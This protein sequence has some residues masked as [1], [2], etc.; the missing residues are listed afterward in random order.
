M[1]DPASLPRQLSLKSETSHYYLSLRGA[2]LP[3]VCLS[4]M[5]PSSVFAFFRLFFFPEALKKTTIFV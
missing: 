5:N 1:A 2:D 3:H 4:G